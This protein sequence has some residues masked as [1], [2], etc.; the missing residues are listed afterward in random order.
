[1]LSGPWKAEYHSGKNASFCVSLLEWILTPTPTTGWPQGKLLNISVSSIVKL[2]Q[3]LSTISQFSEG[4]DEWL[5]E[6]CLK[7]CLVAGA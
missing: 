2:E 1:M 5:H 4:L 7:Y 6:K 3:E